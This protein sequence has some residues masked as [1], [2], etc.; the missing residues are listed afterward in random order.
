MHPFFARF[1]PIR[2]VQDLRGYLSRRRPYEVVFLIGSF[3]VTMLVI[4][5]FVI[6]SHVARPYKRDI[7]YFQNWPENRSAA[8]IRAAQA[9]DMAVRTKRDVAREK[10]QADLKDQFK[11]LDDKLTKWGI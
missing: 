6:D 8:D 4:V 5:G 1:A 11:R 3:M 10:R 7:V 2:A 9:R